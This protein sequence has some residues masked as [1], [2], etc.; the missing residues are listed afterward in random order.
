M[1]TVFVKP[2]SAVLLSLLA[3]CAALAGCNKA[4]NGRGFQKDNPTASSPEN[5][6][7]VLPGKHS[8]GGKKKGKKKGGKSNG[9]KGTPKPGKAGKPGKPEKPAAAATPPP[10]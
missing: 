10:P 8:H 6:A 1:P 9:D 3:L 4:D 5:T 7:N 2:A